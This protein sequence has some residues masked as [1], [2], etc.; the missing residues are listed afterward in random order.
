MKYYL[1]SRAVTDWRGRTIIVSEPCNCHPSTLFVRDGAPLIHILPLTKE[2]YNKCMASIRSRE[3][4][5]ASVE[6]GRIVGMTIGIII[7]IIWFYQPP[8]F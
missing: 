3:R 1:V 2:Q 5:N 8:L 4:R 6:W 7:L